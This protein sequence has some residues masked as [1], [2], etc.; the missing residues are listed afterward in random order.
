MGRT[1]PQRAEGRNPTHGTVFIFR[2]STRRRKHG[3]APHHTTRA[4]GGRGSASA[5]PTSRARA[6][7]RPAA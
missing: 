6:P 7:P 4:G 2:P 3:T 1:K 5:R